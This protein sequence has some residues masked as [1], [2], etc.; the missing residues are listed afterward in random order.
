MAE[1]PW[2]MEPAEHLTRV[3]RAVIVKRI[4]STIDTAEERAKR[5]IR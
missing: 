2:W 4:I 1:Q 3:E 5:G